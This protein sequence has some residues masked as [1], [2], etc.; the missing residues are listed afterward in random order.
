V[1]LSA[2]CGLLGL[3]SWLQTIGR[4]SYIE[5]PHMRVVPSEP[6][7]KPSSQTDDSDESTPPPFESSPQDPPQFGSAREEARY[8]LQK[9]L[10]ARD[11][12]KP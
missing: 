3:S 5:S 8:F 4:N 12:T 9:I 2:T 10:A 6:I 11:E 7:S 1:A